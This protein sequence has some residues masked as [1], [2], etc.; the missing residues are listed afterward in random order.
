MNSGATPPKDVLVTAARCADCPDPA[1]MKA[2]PEQVD[3]RA[4]FAFVA[5][6]G[7]PPVTWRMDERE[8]EDFAIEAIEKSFTPWL[9]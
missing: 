4:V 9:H 3:L 6:Q 2:C 7:I 1:C 5:G 8:A